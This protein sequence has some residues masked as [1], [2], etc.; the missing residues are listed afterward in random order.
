MPHPLGLSLQLSE[1]LRA[2]G[3]VPRDVAPWP[4]PCQVAPLEQELALGMAPIVEQEPQKAPMGQALGRQVTGQVRRQATSF[5]STVAVEPSAAAAAVVEHPRHRF[6][7]RARLM[8]N[9]IP[10]S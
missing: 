3:D 4:K 2:A 1:Q 7:N 10:K 9:L 6:S 8:K 5:P